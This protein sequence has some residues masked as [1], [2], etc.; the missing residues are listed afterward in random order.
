MN[1]LILLILFIYLAFQLNAQDIVHLC[2]GNTHNFAI[3]DNLTSSF[4]WRVSDTTLVSFLTSN[5]THH[6]LLDLNNPGVCKLIVEEIDVNGCIAYDSI[7]IKIHDPPNPSIFAVGNI[8]FCEGDSIR[9][10]LDSIYS[11]MLWNNGST[12][13]FTYVDS[14]GDYFVSVIDSVG[15]MNNSFSISVNVHPKPV[16]DFSINGF[17][18]NRN[19][20]FID[21]SF[22]LLDSIIMK[23][24]DLGGETIGYGDSINNIYTVSG[25]YYT[26]MI[27]TSDFGCMDSIT[28]SF[29]IYNNPIADF[30]YTPK[31]ISTIKPEIDF[32]NHSFNSSSYYW[33]MNDSIG[34][35]LNSTDN[36]SKSPYYEFYNPGI[37]EVFLIVEDTNYCV[38][39]V[40]HEIIMYYDFVFYM[41]KSFTPNNDNKNETFGPKGLRM[42]HYES[43]NFIIYNKW[44][45][46][47]FNTDK[48]PEY[49]LQGEC[50]ENCWKG[51]NSSN[52]IYSWLIIIK[53]ELGKIRKEMGN[54]ILIR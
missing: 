53:D 13:F 33:S 38:D 27:V 50:I 9:L 30:D 22:I 8:D 35:Y 1:R 47:V 44:G 21:Q 51:D 54:V 6:V 43:Y 26:K 46:E 36:T 24:W 31:N 32:L 19:T 20:T 52:G 11:N 14:L 10:E 39:S 29:S 37:Y 3:T 28:K 16:V 48:I 5:L 17:C 15:C 45:G 18:V 23:Q 42:D 2:R 4:S 7:L 41:P 25:D 34:S 12:D 40:S 49:N